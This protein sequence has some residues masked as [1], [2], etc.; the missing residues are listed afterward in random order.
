MAWFKQAH[1]ANTSIERPHL[2]EK[3]LH[4]AAGL[5]IDSLLA[6]DGW[7]DHFKKIHK[8]V[9]ETVSGYSAIV[10]PETVMDWKS[11]ELT[12][13][14]GRYQ[15]KDMVNVVETGLFCNFQSSKTLT[16]EGGFCHGGTKPKQRVTVVLGCNADG[17]EKLPSLVT[18]KCNKP[19]CCRNVKNSPPD[20]QQILIH[21]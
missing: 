19:H 16:Y 2:K 17:T 4:V 21:G 1:N 9:Y 14:N 10:N 6:S 20:T 13:I 7:I 5:G 3:P 11:K 8:L 18:G 12:K 15:P